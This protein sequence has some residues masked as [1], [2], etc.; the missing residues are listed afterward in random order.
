MIGDII[1]HHQ[2]RRNIIGVLLSDSDVKVRGRQIYVM[3]KFTC[4]HCP[5]VLTQPTK[6]QNKDLRID[7]YDIGTVNKEK[8]LISEIN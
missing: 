6:T 7:F 5:I 1:N 3:P 4:L 8:T 2:L